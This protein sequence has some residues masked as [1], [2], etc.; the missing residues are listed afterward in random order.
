M[1]AEVEV[2]KWI[3]EHVEAA[4]DAERHTIIRS[5]CLRLE[6]EQSESGPTDGVRETFVARTSWLLVMAILMGV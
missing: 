4:T 5:L 3:S 1:Q 6:P 2:A